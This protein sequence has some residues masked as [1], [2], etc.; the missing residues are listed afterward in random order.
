M[1]ITPI[2]SYGTAKFIVSGTA[3]QGNYT[4]IQS[5]ITAASSGDDIFI[6]PGIY[7]ENLTLKSGVNLTGFGCDGINQVI[8]SG[9]ATLTSGAVII[10]NLQM[11]AT[12]GV[13]ITV[14]GA[15]ASVL[16]FINCNCSA[17]GTGFLSFTS[18]NSGS[19]VN[20]YGCTGNI[21][22]GQYLFSCSSTGKVLLQNCNITGS[23]N[24]TASTTSSTAIIINNSYI[25]NPLS[26]SSTGAFTIVNSQIDAVSANTAAITSAGSGTSSFIN[27]YLTSGT[28][29]AV[30]AGT[31][32]TIILS[33]CT[34]SSSNTNAVTGAGTVKYDLIGYTGSSSTVNTTTVTPLAVSFPLSVVI[35]TFTGNGTYTPTAGM[36]YCIIE[37]L[38]G[39]GGG[40][41]ATGGATGVSAGGGGGAGGYSKKRVSAATI[42]ASQ[43]VTVGTGGGGG[44]I[45]NNPG[46]AGNTSSVGAIISATGGNGGSG[47]GNSAITAV[48]FSTGGTGGVGSSGD[49]NA[50]GA[51]GFIGTA[52]LHAS[53]IGYV[54]S[55]QGA[56]SLYGGGG[57][58]IGTG[59][60]ISATGGNATVYGAGGGGGASFQN[61]TGGAGGSG[62]AGIV[63]ITEYVIS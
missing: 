37:V 16:D 42:G 7:G 20:F 62:S 55:G 33:K 3:G 1:S 22:A 30:S 9:N 2:S 10:S 35:Q 61:A 34:I 15:S 49:I 47:M 45:G 63:V 18:S 54:L 52:F 27:C 14:S 5:A 26:T 50:N 25:Q 24:S 23:G 21:S 17:S 59:A 4:T 51:T 53:T 11:S 6:R 29:S 40:G 60:S 39:G 43:S 38:G 28:A 44:A 31:G 12:I 41:G 46:T 58:G 36:V 57:V 19:S 8:I 13:A 56:N 32:T 48:N